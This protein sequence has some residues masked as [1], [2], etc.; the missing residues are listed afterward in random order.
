MLIQYHE[1]CIDGGV[2]RILG[3]DSHKLSVVSEAVDD[4]PQQ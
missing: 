2:V 3:Q 1:H 4:G